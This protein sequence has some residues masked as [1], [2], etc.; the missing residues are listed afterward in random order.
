[1]SAD[2]ETMTT[3][4]APD[5]LLATREDVKDFVELVLDDH[6]TIK[7]LVEQMAYALKAVEVFGEAVA[8]LKGSVEHMF[9]QYQTLHLLERPMYKAQKLAVDAHDSAE[10]AKAQVQFALKGQEQLKS[11]IMSLQLA[12]KVQNTQRDEMVGK[13]AEKLCGHFEI[14]K[15]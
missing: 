14:S 15:D 9:Q 13:L 6:S 7:Q 5:A 1:M 11:A 8:D 10:T 2:A 12:M 3:E 4:P